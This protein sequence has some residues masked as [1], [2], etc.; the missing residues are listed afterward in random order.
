M[1]CQ[2]C[3]QAEPEA[4][5][6][7][8]ETDIKNLDKQNSSPQERNE[9]Y[10]NFLLIFKSKLPTFGSYLDSDFNSLIPQK[11]QEYI[12]ENPCSFEPSLLENIKSYEIHPIEF[13]NGNIYIKEGGVPT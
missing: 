1:G 6:P 11:I 7:L 2:A 10:D 9:D 13:Q 3:R 5:F 4:S 8:I 12:T